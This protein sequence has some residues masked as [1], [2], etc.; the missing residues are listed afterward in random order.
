MLRDVQQGPNVSNSLWWPQMTFGTYS[1][2]PRTQNHENMNGNACLHGLFYVCPI[3]LLAKCN[4]QVL[5]NILEFLIS[6]IP[7]K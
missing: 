6:S 5:I 7:I 3:D 1:I 2:T 4:F